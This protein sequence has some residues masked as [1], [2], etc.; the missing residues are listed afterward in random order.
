M[1]P[2]GSSEQKGRCLTCILE[3]PLALA[4][5]PAEGVKGRSREDHEEA[6][7]ITQHGGWGQSTP[8]RWEM[9]PL[10]DLLGRYS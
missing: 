3:G 10:L 2:S 9:W 6:V 7:A 4:V 1:M 8:W 5:W